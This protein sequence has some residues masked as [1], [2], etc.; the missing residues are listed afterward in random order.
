MKSVRLDRSLKYAVDKKIN[1]A[2][3]C[4][5]SHFNLSQLTPFSTLTHIDLSIFVNILAT[6]ATYRKVFFNTKLVF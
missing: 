6:L 1:L 3:K 4:R 5:R 2:L